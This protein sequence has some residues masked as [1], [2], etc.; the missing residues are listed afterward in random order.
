MTREESKIELL[1]RLSQGALRDQN[2]PGW[3]RLEDETATE[4]AVRTDL[5]AR[6]LVADEEARILENRAVAAFVGAAADEE[7]EALNRILFYQGLER[8]LNP[9]DESPRS[10]RA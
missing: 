1:E 8:F 4:Y 3:Q 6:A 5:H 9:E 7:L 10:I 2:F